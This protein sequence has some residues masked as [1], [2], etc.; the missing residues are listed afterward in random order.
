ML[1]SGR[2]ASIWPKR[3]LCHA[4]APR[5][6]R[7]SFIV[8]F[9]CALG[10][11]CWGD[12]E[13]GWRLVGLSAGSELTVFS[14]SRSEISAYKVGD[15]IA[16]GQWRV[17][18][19][20]ASHVVLEPV[21]RTPAEAPSAAVVLNVGQEVPDAS[22]VKPQTSTYYEVRGVVVDDGERQ[23]GTDDAEQRP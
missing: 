3:V 1:F 12:E 19:V 17:E 9:C 8:L 15:R 2:R 21:R 4:A 5:I 13:H 16:D 10:F 14:D 6:V 20:A 7:D 22:T 23:A 18:S 11:S